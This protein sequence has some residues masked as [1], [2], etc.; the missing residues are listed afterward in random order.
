MAGDREKS[1]AAGCNEYIL[2][3]TDKKLFIDIL[4]KYLG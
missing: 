3:P 1:I 2:K 4:R